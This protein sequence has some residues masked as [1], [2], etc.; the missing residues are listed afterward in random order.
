MLVSEER[1]FS[2]SQLLFCFFTRKCQQVMEDCATLPIARICDEIALSPRLWCSVDVKSDGEL[3]D[4]LIA[5]LKVFL[6]CDSRSI[7]QWTCHRA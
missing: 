1:Y 4:K 3:Q 7:A 6:L 5:L 2:S